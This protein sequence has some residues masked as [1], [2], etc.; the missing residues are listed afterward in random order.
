[1]SEYTESPTIEHEVSLA[2]AYIREGIPDK[3]H[4]HLASVARSNPRESAAWD[5]LGRIWRDSGFSRFGLGDAYRAVAFAPLS[6]SAHNTLGTILQNL[7]EGKRARQ[8]FSTALELDPTAS[9]AQNNI[10]Y[11][12][13]M[14]GEVAAAAVA[15]QHALA[16]DPALLPARNN[17]ALARADGG[18]LAGAEALFATTGGEA[19]AQYN[20]GVFLLSQGRYEAAAAAFDKAILLQPELTKAAAHARQARRQA[21]SAERTTHERR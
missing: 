10:C 7:G 19:I 1:L 6:P 4:E 13:L 14:E 12:W 20:I 11:S 2:W 21:R 15:C 17:L 9:Y 3:A 5:A 8:A 16:L 18:D